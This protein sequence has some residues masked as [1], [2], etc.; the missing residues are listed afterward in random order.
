M[1]TKGN[2]VCQPQYDDSELLRSKPMTK[3]FKMYKIF[4]FN[5]PQNAVAIKSINVTAETSGQMNLLMN[6]VGEYDQM[7]QNV[8]MSKKDQSKEEKRH[9]YE[10]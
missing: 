3:N 8:I 5:I 9:Q 2:R 10:F 7:S 4:E 6:Y 1:Q